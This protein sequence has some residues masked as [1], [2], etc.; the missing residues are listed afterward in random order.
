MSEREKRESDQKP[1]LLNCP[2]CGSTRFEVQ[3]LPDGQLRSEFPLGDGFACAQCGR[4]LTDE[5][6]RPATKPEEIVALVDA[7][8]GDQEQR[9]RV[10]FWK[11]KVELMSRVLA[12]P[13]LQEGADPAVYYD[14]DSLTLREAFEAGK[15]VEQV[16]TEVDEEFNK[17]GW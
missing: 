15:T 11:W 10:A 7:V 6:G 4:V 16:F 3:F 5:K 2:L 13:A 9:A 8:V 14:L 17:W 1:D 12:H